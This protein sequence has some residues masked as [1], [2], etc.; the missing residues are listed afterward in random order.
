[1]SILNNKPNYKQSLLQSKEF[2]FFLFLFFLNSLLSA[3]NIQDKIILTH[4]DSLALENVIVEK[5]Y[6]SDSTDYSDTLKNALPIGSITYRIFIDMK[7]EY[8]LQLVYGNKNHELNI[9]TSTSIFNDMEAD[10][11]TGFNIN[12][13]YIYKGNIAL[14][15]WITMGA[16]SRGFTGIPRVE[17]KDEI[18]LITNR[19]SFKK[20]DG[21]TKAILPNFTVYNL[22][23][24]PF[25]YDTT[26]SRFSTN[27]GGWAA[28]GGAK[29]PNAD[30]KVLIAQ[31][32]T[33]GKLSFKLNVQIGT[34]TGGYIKF[35]ADKPE[36]N[37]IQ[38]VGLNFK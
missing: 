37:E 33:N 5:Y 20:A 4:D 10:A 24:K 6:F 36:E 15:S 14:D 19:E 31:I 18:S 22:N 32:T 13:K 23:L 29:G 7:P 3:Q 17:D 28:P 16:A 35:V 25:E 8:K 2:L 12:T 9:E 26:A 38:F 27:N 30:N 21:L 1:M 34:P 11:V